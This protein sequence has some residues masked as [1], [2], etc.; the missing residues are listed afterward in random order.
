M[1][2]V[3]PPKLVKRLLINLNEVKYNKALIFIQNVI[4]TDLIT[5]NS[6]LSQSSKNYKSEKKAQV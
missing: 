4:R 6:T 1:D 3:I 2:T 5:K